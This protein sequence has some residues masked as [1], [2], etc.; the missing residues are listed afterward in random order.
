LENENQ[1]KIFYSYKNTLKKINDDSI[2]INNVFDIV[3]A[4]YLAS[5]SVKQ[6][7]SLEEFVVNQ[8]MDSKSIAVTLYTLKQ[9]LQA[10]LKELGMQTLYYDVE[11]KLAYILFRMEGSGFNVDYTVLDNLSEKYLKKMNNLKD[12]IHEQAGVKFNVNS[13][14][15]LSEILFDK[16]N[17]KTYNNNKKS[18]G[19]SVLEK[20]RGKHPI[21]ELVIEYRKVSKLLNTYIEA[22]KKLVSPKDTIIH[23]EFNQTLTS[24]GR[25]SSSNPNL[26]NI[27][28][29][30]PQGR[31][32]RKMFISRFAN[33]KLVSADYS[34]I[35]LRLLAHYSKD[36]KLV[37]AYK[38]GKDIHSQ[39]ASDIFGIPL[40][41]VT[42]EQRRDAKAVNFG[43]IY[44]ISDYGLSQNIGSTRVNAKDYIDKYFETYP[45]VKKFMDNA[46][47]DAKQKGYV[48]TIMGRTR[49]I[50]E[51]NSKNYFLKQAAQRAAMNMP[52]QGSASDI[53]KKAMIK[54]YNR[55]KTEKL[56]S[57]LILQVHDEII[58]D[59]KQDELQKIKKILKEEMENVTK[60]N[61][62]LVVDINVG[63]S[64]YDAK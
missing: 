55:I 62:P 18:T 17:I 12:K 10:K 35:E 49:I 60:L 41:K 7:S 47:K 37:N 13:P 5:G 50:K 58:V 16:L 51:I 1:E 28:I 3:I 32:L 63:D 53:I 9:N 24:T 25:L 42:K 36:E 30:T 56:E 59:A 54:V 15:Q 6:D 33:G 44:G 27:P 29:R 40:D 22:F 20:I 26:Q 21:I 2:N 61:I 64:L 4:N 23:T 19:M 11:I 46:V 38:Q 52:L 14:K 48:S 39:T 45:G 43:I 34:Q 31:E 57:K 8:N